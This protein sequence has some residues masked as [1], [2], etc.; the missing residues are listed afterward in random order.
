MFVLMLHYEPSLWKEYYPHVKYN[1]VCIE[2]HKCTFKGRIVCI[3]YR[4]EN[5]LNAVIVKTK[6]SLKGSIC[7]VLPT[8]KYFF[9][10]ILYDTWL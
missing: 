4:I 2:W 1:P 10:Y 9:L 7:D 8:G 3:K 6:N 5:I